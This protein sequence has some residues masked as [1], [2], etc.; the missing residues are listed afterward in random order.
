MP[1]FFYENRQ[2]IKDTII[3][4]WGKRGENIVNK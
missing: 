3:Q 2:D 1:Y 4:L